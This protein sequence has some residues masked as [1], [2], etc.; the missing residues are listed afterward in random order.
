MDEKV[1]WREFDLYTQ[2]LNGEI[3]ITLYKNIFSCYHVKYINREG[4]ATVC[5]SF[6]FDRL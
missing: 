6:I 4:K 2:V 1:I 3:K 5:Y